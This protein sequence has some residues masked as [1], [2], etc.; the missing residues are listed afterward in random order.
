MFGLLCSAKST[1]ILIS[2][3]VKAV[4]E[5]RLKIVL[6]INFHGWVGGV[7]SY[8]TESNEIRLSQIPF[9]LILK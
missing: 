1:I 6:K 8:M 3:I 9:K 7:G 5:V 4:V 2:N